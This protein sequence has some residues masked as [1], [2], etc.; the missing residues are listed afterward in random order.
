MV[1]GICVGY[2][3]VRVCARENDYLMKINKWA[4]S[5]T[6]SL[7]E[8]S[9]VIDVIKRTLYLHVITSI[10]LLLLLLLYLSIMYF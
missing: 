8:I 3:R 4:I 1:C 10:L 6:F 9:F 5:V 2:P 7:S